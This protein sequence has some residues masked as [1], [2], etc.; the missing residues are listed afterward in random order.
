MSLVQ[1]TIMTFYI[2]LLL[3]STALGVVNR[4]GHL[5]DTRFFGFFGGS[6]LVFHLSLLLL[7]AIH[8]C[9]FKS[10]CICCVF[11]VLSCLLNKR[12]RKERAIKNGQSRD[13]GNIGQT[14][15]GTKTKLNE[16]VSITDHT[17]NTEGEPNGS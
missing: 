9:A 10:C 8:V 6:C 13:T 12:S 17:K 4:S 14:R 15:P 16:K 7:C 11:L 5:A 3:G 1:K 2:H